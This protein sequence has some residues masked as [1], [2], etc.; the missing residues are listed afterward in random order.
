MGLLMIFNGLISNGGRSFIGTL[1]YSPK[2][3]IG[4]LISI[5]ILAIL[6][7]FLRLICILCKVLI[8]SRP[9]IIDCIQPKDPRESLLDHRHLFR[10]IS[11]E[12]IQSPALG[13][14]FT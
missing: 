6:L 8:F 9:L 13:F 2:E 1:I 12:D 4:S 7:A 5:M 11:S 3:G 10:Q 14:E